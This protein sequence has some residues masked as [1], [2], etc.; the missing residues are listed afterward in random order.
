MPCGGGTILVRRAGA[1]TVRAGGAPM[2]CRT[3]RTGYVH[4]GS[5]SSQQSLC[6]LR[7]SALGD[8]THVLP[9]VNRIRAERPA[10]AITW[11][12]GKAEHGLLEGLPGVEFVVYDKRGGR[13]AISGL[14]QALG[15]RRF[16]VLLQMQLALRAN[17]LSSLVGARRRIGYDRGRSKEG[18]GLVVNE[19]I[20]PA[21]QHVLDVF[22]QFTV[23]LG[24]EPGPV[25]WGIP[26]PRE[27]TDW[28][29]AQWPGG[30][31]AMVISA[32]SSH[33][34]RNWHAD[35][36]AALAGHA[37][38]RGWQ[39]VLIG[40]RSALERE[41]GNAI[42]ERC[43]AAPLDLIGR[44]TLK[45]MVALLARA[46]LVVAPDS[47][48]VHVANAVGTP[49][50]GLYACTDAE[51]SGPYSDR[52]WTVNRYAEAAERFMRRPPE[53]LRWG[54]RVEKPG[55]MDLITVDEVIG[56]FDAFCAATGRERPGQPGA[57]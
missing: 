51:R 40:G 24:I 28:A 14:R 50:L 54:Q 12:T 36:Y 7:L 47:G 44:D 42:L 19:R 37:M 38:T 8:V 20:P 1:A 23:P 46:D 29:R 35:G 52:R 41:V 43:P 16:D 56:R 22:R 25:D 48:P 15:G 10:W 9:V 2:P 3:P 5:P 30:R 17:L 18:H 53:R 11:V 45:Q 34:L 33:P 55:V 39:V 32:C 13:R 21:G 57:P 49:V 6:I 31:R 26:L 4:P 27:A